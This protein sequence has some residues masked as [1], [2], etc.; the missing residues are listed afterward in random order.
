MCCPQGYVFHNF[1]LGRVLFLAQQSG[2]GH[3]FCLGRVL[4]SGPIEGVF[5]SWFDTAVA[6]VNKRLAT[7]P[8]TIVGC[9]TVWTLAQQTHVKPPPPPP[10]R[11]KP[12]VKPY[13]AGPQVLVLLTIICYSVG[14]HVIT[15][16][17]WSVQC[18]QGVSLVCQTTTGVHCQC[19][20]L[21]S[22][23]LTDK[24]GMSSEF[25]IVCRPI[26]RL[27]F[28]HNQITSHWN[29]GKGCN[30]PLFFLERVGNFCLGRVKVC[31]PGLHTPIHNLVKSFPPPPLWG[32]GATLDSSTVRNMLYGGGLHY[33]LRDICGRGL[34]AGLTVHVY[35]WCRWRAQGSHTHPVKPHDFNSCC[36]GAR[37]GGSEIDPMSKSARFMTHPNPDSEWHI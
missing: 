8:E 34:F 20:G 22:W 15:P 29:S 24:A 9:F 33:N 10:A 26:F 4:F 12:P 14:L 5:W 30:I 28:Y 23:G 7:S 13:A 19:S 11:V 16:V 6:S 25:W 3:G 36:C 2:K 18:V 32:R 21:R 27:L 31:H 35:M 17:Y 37:A 1:C